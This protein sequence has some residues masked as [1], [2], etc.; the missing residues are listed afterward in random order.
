MVYS[1]LSVIPFFKDFIYDSWEIKERGRDIG[2]GEAGSLR[3]PRWGTLHQDPRIITGAKADAQPLSHPGA[4]FFKCPK[5][6]PTSVI[7]CVLNIT[8]I[9]LSKLTS[10]LNSRKISFKFLQVSS[11][12]WT[13]FCTYANDIILYFL[14]VNSQRSI[15]M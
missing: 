11:L 4:P 9:H 6:P 10:Y 12:S 15:Q 7:C 3:G 14:C 2:E 8:H 13:Y 1:F 5:P